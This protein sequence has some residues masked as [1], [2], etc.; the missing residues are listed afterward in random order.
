MGIRDL[1]WKYEPSWEEEVNQFE[2]PLAVFNNKS[3]TL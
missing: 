2:Y 1:C 3:L